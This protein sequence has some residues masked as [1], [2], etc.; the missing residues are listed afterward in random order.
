MTALAA[1]CGPAPASAES[2]SS[3]LARAY[4]DNPDINQQRAAVRAKDEGVPA[5]KSG[6]LPH[7]NA[8][9]SA[10]HQVTNTSNLFGAGGSQKLVGN[11]RGPTVTVTQ[12]V[13]DGNRT[14]NSV[15]AAESSVLQQRE[16]MRDSES[17]HPAAR[18][19]RLYGRVARYGGARS[20][21]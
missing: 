17:D 19:H 16:T 5:A 7:A 14:A 3:A 4:D 11:P 20:A 6:W 9:Y 2:M 15:R 18:R 10:G 12:T 21:P 13:W 1:L 8:T